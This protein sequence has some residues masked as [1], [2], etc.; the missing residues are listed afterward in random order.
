MYVVYLRHLKSVL[1]YAGDENQ[2]T[3]KEDKNDGISQGNTPVD[4]GS[5]TST[6]KSNDVSK[7]A[8]SKVTINVKPGKDPIKDTKAATPDSV[9][10]N[11]TGFSSL[12]FE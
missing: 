11:K 3:A 9:T 8:S 6:Q 12:I 7:P 2:T 10:S 5:N 4:S 1:L